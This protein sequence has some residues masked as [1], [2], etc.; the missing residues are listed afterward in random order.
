VWSDWGAAAGFSVV[1][2]LIFDLYEK[3]I[4]PGPSFRLPFLPGAAKSHG[5]CYG[6]KFYDQW[7]VIRGKRLYKNIY[8][9]CSK[10]ID[11]SPYKCGHYRQW[12]QNQPVEPD[13]RNAIQPGAR[14]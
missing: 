5:K 9:P 13:L 2:L 14:G 7:D 1:P 12:F 11:A 3:I 6:Y 10:F 8:K 4:N